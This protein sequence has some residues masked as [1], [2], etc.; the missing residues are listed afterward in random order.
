MPNANDIN[1]V[2]APALPQASTQYNLR[3]M[4]QFINVLR[5]YFNNL[6]NAFNGLLSSS[7]GGS[8]LYKPYASFYSSVDQTAAV[9]NTA[10]EIS[11]ENTRNSKGITINGGANT[12]ITVDYKGSYHIHVTLQVNSNTGSGGDVYVWVKKNGTNIADSCQLIDFAGTGNHQLSYT[13]TLELAAS[14]VISFEWAVSNTN[15]S[16]AATAAS[17][18]YP[19]IPSA[20]ATILYASN[21]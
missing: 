12:D 19:A 1:Q 3:Y 7:S 6:N 9:I 18:P 2:N 8:A 5:L 14:D 10:Y 16:L 11:F 20:T 15:L 17:S 13:A 4:N 21:V